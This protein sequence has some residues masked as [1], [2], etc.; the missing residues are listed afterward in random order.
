LALT[1]WWVVSLT[2]GLVLL[3]LAPIALVLRRGRSSP[4]PTAVT[5]MAAI[6]AVGIFLLWRGQWVGGVDALQR[7]GLANVSLVATAFVAA[8]A[9]SVVAH[10]RWNETAPGILRLLFAAAVLVA[11]GMLFAFG[12]NN[13]LD[14]QLSLAGGLVLA[15]AG[16]CGLACVPRRLGA[17]VL[18]G[19]A[20][21]AASVSL[22]TVATARMNPYRTAS[23]DAPS[24]VIDFGQ[25]SQRLR[26]DLAAAT[27]W[28][29]LEADARRAGWRAG[30]RLLDL[31]WSP[32]VPYALAA[33]VPE[34]LFPSLQGDTATASAIEAL[35]LSDAPAWRDAWV[36]VS[37]D[38]EGPR[39]AE[40]LATSGR[41]FPDDYSL[42]TQLVAPDS[43]LSVQLWRPSLP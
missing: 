36:L 8:L 32:A 11:A 6:A 24:V 30:T 34:T 18:V 37:P 1:P 38:L 33:T 41:R 39:P 13:G 16:L 26:V 4:L 3:G 25:R 35:R 19:F 17:H 2:F 20:V 28:G 23:P 15:A 14:A 5:A 12:S 22:L 31:T 29:T 42:V 9:S 21:A 43:N 10:R 7:I 40:I 27:F